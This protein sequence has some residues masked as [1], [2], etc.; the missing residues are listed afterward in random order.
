LI[1]VDGLLVP[2]RGRAG[3]GQAAQGVGDRAPADVDG[4]RVLSHFNWQEPRLTSARP[5]VRWSTRAAGDHGGLFGGLGGFLDTVELL[6]HVA[7]FAQCGRGAAGITGL[8]CWT[9]HPLVREVSNL[10]FKQEVKK[11]K[12]QALWPRS[13]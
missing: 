4:R 2:S 1:G 5:S 12:D 6:E 3:R 11:V 13:E 8:A 10:L 9:L 7:E